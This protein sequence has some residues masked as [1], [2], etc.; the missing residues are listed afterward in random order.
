[1]NKRLSVA[2]MPKRIDALSRKLLDELVVYDERTHRAFC[3]NESAAAVWMACDGKTTLNDVVCALRSK[4]DQI[5]ERFIQLALAELRKSGLLLAGTA[6]SN[7]FQPLSRR[8]L[9]R[10]LARVAGFAVPIVTSIV[11]ASPAQ[12]VSCFPLLHT[13]VRNSD[14]CSQHCGIS[15]VTRVCLP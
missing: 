14:C 2:I 9:I 15:G 12:A 11:V 6:S 3:L 8:K 7:D 4:F 5:D 1:M 13:C 10:K